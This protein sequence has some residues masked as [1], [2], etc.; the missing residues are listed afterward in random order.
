MPRE[1]RREVDN[2]FYLT[3]S[4]QNIIIPT[5][6][7]S[8]KNLGEL[9]HTLSFAPRLQHLTCHLRLWHISFLSGCI[10]VL[11]SQCDRG[12]PECPHAG[13][14]TGGSIRVTGQLVGK[15]DFAPALLGQDC[16]LPPRAVRLRGSV[17]G[18]R[19]GRDRQSVCLEEFSQWVS[20]GPW[21]GDR[22]ERLPRST[23]ENSSSESLAPH[24]HKRG[25][26]ETQGLRLCPSK[27]LTISSFTITV[28]IV[29]V[30]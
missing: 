15:A 29:T 13:W 18:A 4:I 5:G 11:S 14:P 26:R 17:C 7:R 30:S 28:A 3:Q 19:G 25:C 1:E 27:L 8:L 6:N 12:G 2:G 10:S 22:S 20:H 9:F 24:S 21:S 23:Q 16:V